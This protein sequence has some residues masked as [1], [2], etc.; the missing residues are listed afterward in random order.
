[1][2]STGVFQGCEHQSY[3]FAQ[4][5]AMLS[6]V[7]LRLNSGQ[8]SLCHAPIVDHLLNFTCL[9]RLPT[10][11]LM[12][13]SAK[14]FRHGENPLWFSIAQ[15]LSEFDVYVCP[16]MR[17]SHLSLHRRLEIDLF[18]SVS[19]LIASV[20]CE[21]KDYDTILRFCVAGGLDSIRIERNLGDLTSATNP[22][23]LA[24][25]EGC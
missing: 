20:G 19:T 14:Y 24:Q 2:G 1:M 10:G 11:E 7:T 15:R 6:D 13:L 18:I 8:P 5:S 21:N 4:L 12:C 17:T 25:L 16:H 22:K 3:N 23:W 9:H